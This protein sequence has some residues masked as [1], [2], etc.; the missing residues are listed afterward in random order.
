MAL[1]YNMFLEQIEFRQTPTSITSDSSFFDSKHLQCIYVPNCEKLTRINYYE[2]FQG[3]SLEGMDWCT[4]QKCQLESV[5]PSN[6]FSLS[7]TLINRDSNKE[8]SIYY[9]IFGL[10]GGVILIVVIILFICLI[11][12]KKKKSVTTNSD[13]TINILSRSIF[14]ENRSY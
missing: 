13:D 9:I 8:K 6:T 2:V 11:R 3:T 7:L 4:V 5:Q 10:L 1:A 12:R 14:W